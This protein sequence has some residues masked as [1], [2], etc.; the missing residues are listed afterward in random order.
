MKVFP[1]RKA[2]YI[3]LETMFDVD[4]SVLTYDYLNCQLT[5][6]NDQSFFGIIHWIA[7]YSI[8]ETDITIPV[9]VV[10]NEPCNPFYQ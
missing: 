1:R 5:V 4:N 2:D 9:E 8:I 10:D 6:F 3:L 7:F